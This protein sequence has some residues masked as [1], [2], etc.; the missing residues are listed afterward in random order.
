[1]GALNS[2]VLCGLRWLM[3]VTVFVF[4]FILLLDFCILKLESTCIHLSLP[5][6]LAC[7]DGGWNKYAWSENYIFLFFF[8]QS[9]ELVL[10]I[11]YSEWIDQIGSSFGALRFQYLQVITVS[12]EVIWIFVSVCSRVIGCQYVAVTAWYCFCLFF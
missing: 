3:C 11:F 7:S 1:M 9:L 8:L 2:F 10:P 12:H 4:G 6:W 5:H